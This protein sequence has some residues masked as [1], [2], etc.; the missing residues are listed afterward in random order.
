MSAVTSTFATLSE[1]SIANLIDATVA[2]EATDATVATEATEA[3][4]ESP[5]PEATVESPAPEAT[6]ESPA[7]EAT[8]ESPAPEATVESPALYKT[9]GEHIAI[10]GVT[11]GYLSGND[12]LSVVSAKGR[13]VDRHTALGQSFAPKALLIAVAYE[14]T[15]KLA[16]NGRYAPLFADISRLLSTQD[17]T[18]LFNNPTALTA[19][20]SEPN[21]NGAI[22]LLRFCV[23]RWTGVKNAEKAAFAAL[24]GELLKT[25]T[26]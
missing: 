21:K 26:K 4:V 22:A 9:D 18:V 20:S 6:V 23:S 15:R 24:C 17:K 16:L 8:V 3:T 19:Y 2:T 13:V 7:P 11:A 12:V 5:A 1:L 10:K 25:L 14:K